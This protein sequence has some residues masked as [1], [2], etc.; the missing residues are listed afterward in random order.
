MRTSLLL[1][2]A[3]AAA[4]A[5]ATSPDTTPASS[6]ASSFEADILRLLQG[7][8]RENEQQ[9]AALQ[10]RELSEQARFHNK[11]GVT[12]A[13]NPQA[14]AAFVESGDFQTTLSR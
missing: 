14:A 9:S 4:L 13:P 3:C 6:S 11:M 7:A 5:L 2:L 10:E 1:M 12:N 8:K